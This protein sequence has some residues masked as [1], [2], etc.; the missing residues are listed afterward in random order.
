MANDDEFIISGAVVATLPARQ[1]R[2]LLRA[3]VQLMLLSSW[4]NA[5][6]QLSFAARVA[7]AFAILK[8]SIGRRCSKKSS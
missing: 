1:E 6:R 8:S 3:E 7:K 2:A 4:L 5:R